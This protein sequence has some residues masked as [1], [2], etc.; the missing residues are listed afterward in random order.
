MTAAVVVG[1]RFRGA[2]G[3]VYDRNREIRIQ[4]SARWWRLCFLVHLLHQTFFGSSSATY[5]CLEVAPFLAALAFILKMP[6]SRMTKDQLRDA[7]ADVGVKTGSKMKK[8][9]LVKLYREKILDQQV[10]TVS[11]NDSLIG[12]FSSDEE[13]PV[14]LD[15]S[16]IT[17]ATNVKHL[18]ND[19]I[20]YKLK[21]LGEHVGPILDST[22]SIY[23]RKL[24]RLL[25]GD[26]A[27]GDNYDKGI[28]SFSADEED[29]ADKDET[30]EYDVVGATSDNTEHFKNSGFSEK[31]VDDNGFSNTLSRE[32]EKIQIQDDG[33]IVRTRRHH[34]IKS[35][36]NE[37]HTANGK[38]FVPPP[39]KKHNLPIVAG[40]ALLVLAVIAVLIC[41]ICLYRVNLESGK[42]FAA[43][44][45]SG[46]AP[47]AENVPTSSKTVVIGSGI[48]GSPK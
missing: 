12:G 26:E 39:P 7:L 48:N 45:S 30:D 34:T 19:E 4:R 18:T 47:P 23:E 3:P 32:H 22:R 24:I 42:P 35:Y 36:T 25:G 6:S 14:A 44:P 27:D 9:E 17:S 20:F 28:S 11:P 13:E 38:S 46:S 5:P 21:E 37:S 43:V 33:S 10:S 16:H 2:I 41:P 1:K 29:E 15:T 40:V 8:A 31:I